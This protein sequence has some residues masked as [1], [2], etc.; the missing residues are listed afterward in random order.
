MM[1][2]VR[3]WF[4]AHG[5]A[6]FTDWHRA[7]DSHRPQTMN[8]AGW[9]RVQW[10][11]GRNTAG[12]VVQVITSIEWLVLPDV[13]RAEI[14]KGWSYRAVLRVLDQ[15]GHLHREKRDGFG[16]SVKP[17]NVGSASVYRIRSTILEGGD[18]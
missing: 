16:C 3:E 6:R 9:R 12:E 17:P 4:G 1:R 5:E 18:D 11:E 7:D 8:R 15:G 10:G 13:F 14:A 2:Q